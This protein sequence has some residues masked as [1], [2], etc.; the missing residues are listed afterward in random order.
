MPCILDVTD[1]EQVKASIKGTVAQLGKIDILV[2]NAGITRDQLVMRMKRADWDAVLQ[3]NLTS[4]YPVS[5]THLDVYKRQL[6]G[7]GD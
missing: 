5:Y 6:P 4:A 7:T 2:N 1:Q 3:T